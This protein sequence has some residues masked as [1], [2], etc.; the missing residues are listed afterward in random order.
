MARLVVFAQ[1]LY[2]GVAVIASC[3]RL[4]TNRPLG[5]ESGTLLWV[6]VAGNTVIG[7]LLLWGV[8]RLSRM[9]SAGLKTVL[10]VEFVVILLT[11]WNLPLGLDVIV[12]AVAVMLLLGR[13]SVRELCLS[14]EPPDSPARVEN[15]RWYARL[16][17]E[18]APPPPRA[19]SP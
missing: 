2:C 13:K 9:T 19:T 18:V 16:R 10:N 1:V 17:D 7:S 15:W 8:V 14:T 11:V 4:E 3:V 6:A 12:P 5:K